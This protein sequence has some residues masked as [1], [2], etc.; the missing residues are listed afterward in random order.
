MVESDAESAAL[1]RPATAATSSDV[2]EPDP[3][4]GRTIGG[5]RLERVLGGGGGGQVYAAHHLRLGRTVAVK[6]IRPS[7]VTEM[8][9]TRRPLASRAAGRS[10]ASSRGG[11]RV[12][13][14]RSR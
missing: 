6:V 10:R 1:P 3:M 14:A 4:L 7:S 9:L 8:G 5:C 2:T 11:E 13:I 12:R